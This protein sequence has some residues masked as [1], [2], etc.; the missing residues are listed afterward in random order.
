MTKRGA[1][2]IAFACALREFMRLK[3]YDNPT[4]LHRDLSLMMGRYAPSSSSVW[5]SFY[6]ERLLPAETLLFMQERFGFKCKWSELLSTE[7]PR[8]AAQSSNQLALPGM[9]ELRDI[10]ESARRAKR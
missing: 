1:P 6:G 8:G 3:N 2:Y 9:R 7:K 5:M 10:Q 4:E